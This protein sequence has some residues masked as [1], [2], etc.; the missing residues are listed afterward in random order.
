MPVLIVSGAPDW[1]RRMPLT[2]QSCAMALAT[3]LPISGVRIP[4]VRLRMCRR[5]SLQR[6]RSKS[7]SSG[8]DQ[9]VP[10]FGR[11][12]PSIQLARWPGCRRQ[13]AGRRRAQT[14]HRARYEP[15]SPS[16]NPSKDEERTRKA[17]KIQHAAG[18]HSAAHKCI[19]NAVAAAGVSR[20]KPRPT[21]NAPTFG[22]ILEADDPR[23]M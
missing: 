11:S 13:A 9:P 17:Y 6:P 19:V 8:L 18:H 3:P 21:V 12:V 16:R 7:G 2:R 20:R 10:M 14:L 23:I 1:A 22:Q 5:S 4:A 15:P